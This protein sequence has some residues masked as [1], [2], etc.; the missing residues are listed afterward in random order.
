MSGFS[1]VAFG[2]GWMAAAV[3]VGWEASW[4]EFLVVW[5]LLRLRLS[6]F[7]GLLVLGGPMP[8]YFF[9]LSAVNKAA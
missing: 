4:P 6:V 7:L 5:Y 9:R 1:G 8:I 3:N 2:L